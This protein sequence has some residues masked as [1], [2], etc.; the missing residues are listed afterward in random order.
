MEKRRED[1]TKKQYAERLF[2]LYEHEVSSIALNFSGSQAAFNHK[3]KIEK[4]LISLIDNFEYR[5]GSY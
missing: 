3:R 1:E 2:S 5:G 4:E